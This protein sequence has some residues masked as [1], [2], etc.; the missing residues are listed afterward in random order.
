MPLVTQLAE[1]SDYIMH[2]LL[3]S[4]LQ[5]NVAC[6]TE[7][8]ETAETLIQSDREMKGTVDVVQLS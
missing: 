7:L 1:L 6:W 4:R 8:K 5:T 2:P 3:V